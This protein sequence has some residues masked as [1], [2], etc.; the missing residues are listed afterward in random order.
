MRSTKRAA[1]SSARGAGPTPRHAASPAGALAGPMV[2]IFDHRYRMWHTQGKLPADFRSLLH[3]QEDRHRDGA[4]IVGQPRH[5]RGP[6]RDDRRRK[7]GGEGLHVP[8]PSALIG[9]A[10]GRGPQSDGSIVSARILIVD[11]EQIIID[12]CLRILERSGYQLEAVQ[13]GLE[14]LRKIDEQPLRHRHPRHHDAEDRRPRGAAAGEGG[15]PG[16]RGHHDHRP[17]RRSRRR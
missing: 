15:A 2:E 14:A 5:H 17:C 3:H 12:S 4:R 10:R 1:S 6:W 16:H 9:V 11:D 13:D 7:R 8:G